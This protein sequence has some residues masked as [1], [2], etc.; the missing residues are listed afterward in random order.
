MGKIY[1]QQYTKPIP[2]DA[3][4]IKTKI[5]RHG[6]MKEVDAVRWK[7]G[8]GKWVIAPTVMSGKQ[9]GTHCRMESPNWYGIVNG[10]P[11]CL[12][13]TNRRAAEAKLAELIAGG[14]PADVRQGKKLRITSLLEQYRI[15][16]ESK[17]RA[18]AYI[19]ET[20]RR[21]ER[22]AEE[23]SVD[24]I[25]ELDF[26]RVSAWLNSIRKDKP[27]PELPNK[28]WWSRKE[29]A[30]LAGI[31]VGS[32]TSLL[33]NH[34]LPGSGQARRRKFPRETVEAILA[35]TRRGASPETVN[36]YIRSLRSFFR[37]LV[38]P[39]RLLS[40]NPL[41]DLQT[42]DTSK[43]RRHDRRELSAEELQRLFDTT[44]ESPVPRRGLPGTSRAL[45]YLTACCTGFRA[46]ALA[47]LTPADFHLDHVPPIVILPARLNKSKKLKRQPI[48]VDAVEQLRTFIQPV[49]AHTL[50]WPGR[51]ATDHK[52]GSMLRF[53]LKAAQIPYRTV[54]PDGPLFADFHALRHSYLTALGRAGVNLRTAQEL[55]GHTSPTMT[56][57]YMHVG[58]DDMANAANRLQTPYKLTTPQGTT[59]DTK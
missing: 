4:P 20:I 29:I 27:T 55:A 33:Y 18:T 46:S 47:G 10:S 25:G 22:V 57:R 59:K 11:V 23:L 14:K 8:S 7:D 13:T 58:L 43:D 16:L 24:V 19:R 17:D 32:V 40:G 30:A 37:W 39:A 45:L 48:P 50:L 53:D 52:A 41:S 9:A 5:R 54:G 51:W 2:S 26:P 1:K 21:I 6:K 12:E 38:K 35:I 15:Y 36:H 3:E 31:Q 34:E 42:L 44:Y 28:P 56:A 49:S